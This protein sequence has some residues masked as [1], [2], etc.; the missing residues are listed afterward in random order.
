MGQKLAIKLL[1]FSGILLG[2]VGC[3]VYTVS[4]ES[5]KIQMLEYPV[6]TQL[7]STDSLYLGPVYFYAYDMEYV[8]VKDKNGKS[9][10]L[11]N[12]PT[13]EARI[14]EYNGRKSVFYF[15]TMELKN[16]S[17]S[18]IRSF[19]NPERNDIKIPFDSIARIEIQN[20]KKKFYFVEEEFTP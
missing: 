9:K 5:F 4:P 20:N 19:L 2:V 1:L 3:Q 12:N 15:D 6:F 8:F 10:F 13:I 18:G 16:D 7:D 11:Q 17:L 14:F